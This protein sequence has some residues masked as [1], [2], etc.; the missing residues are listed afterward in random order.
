METTA[1]ISSSEVVRDVCKAVTVELVTGEL[2]HLLQS[3]TTKRS[4]YCFHAYNLK[5][6]ARRL[7]I[8]DHKNFLFCASPFGA[9][10]LVLEANDTYEL[11]SV[12]LKENLDS[13]VRKIGLLSLIW[14]PNQIETIGIYSR[15]RFRRLIRR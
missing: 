9:Y 12:A 13:V 14:A 7:E 6:Q 11:Y 4:Q 1:E 5:E 3:E 15:V 10:V 8:F 2:I